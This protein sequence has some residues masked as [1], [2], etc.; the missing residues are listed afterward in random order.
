MQYLYIIIYEALR[1]SKQIDRAWCE[2]KWKAEGNTHF[3]DKQYLM[4]AHCYSRALKHCVT[5]RFLGVLM[6][7]SMAS[8]KVTDDEGSLHFAAAPLQHCVNDRFL[9]VLINAS[10]P[11]RSISDD[12]GSLRFAAAPLQHSGGSTCQRQHCASAAL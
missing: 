4:T 9:G 12:K 6:N 8:R 5:D 7:E 3:A 11:S 10:I 2:S 1:R